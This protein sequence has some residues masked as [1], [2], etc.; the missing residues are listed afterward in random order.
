VR[1]KVDRASERSPRE[2]PTGASRGRT[3][4]TAAP[5]NAAIETEDE[6]E[7]DALVCHRHPARE[8]RVRCGRCDLPICQRCAMQGPVGWRCIDCGRAPRDP[9][10]SFAP[11]EL[12]IGLAVAFG[13][14]TIAG[15]V[16]LRLGFLLSI[17]IGPFVGGLIGEAVMRATGYKRGRGVRALV[18]GGIVGGLLIAVAVEHLVLT[19]PLPAEMMGM[20]VMA[21]VMATSALSGIVYV[22]AATFGAF[23]RLR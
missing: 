18:L 13:A 20:D 1:A 7:H 16:G 5:S 22:A 9:L 21:T 14:G 12:A 10:T 3:T 4:D 6:T 17:C 8:T 11:S 19:A 15:L 23:A 2:R